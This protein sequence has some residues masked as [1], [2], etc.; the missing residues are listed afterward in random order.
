MQL[1]FLHASEIEKLNYNFG[2]NE[3]NYQHIINGK[4]LDIIKLQE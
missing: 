1:L 4:T 3:Q 2:E